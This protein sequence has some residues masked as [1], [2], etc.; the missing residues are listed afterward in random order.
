MI[1]PRKKAVIIGGSLGGLFAGTLL[2]SIGWD[3]DIYERSKGDLDSRGGGI[4][5][6]PE[7][8][9]VMR[10][11]GALEGLAA[12]GV[13]SRNRVVF[14]PDGSLLH[15]DPAPQTQTSWSL[16]YSNLKKL[17]PDD[18]YHR[19]MTLEDIKQVE[20]GSFATAIFA[21]GTH[22]SGDIVIGA[23]GNGSSVRGLLWLEAEPS[24]AGYTAWRGL[25]PESEMPPAAIRDLHGDFAFASNTG[26]H[27]LG[28]LVPGDHSDV[29]KGHRLYNWVW[30]RVMDDAMR[31]D[32][33]TDRDGR[34]RH[35]SIPEGKLSD[36]WRD[37]VYSEA[38]AL[39][40]EGFRDVVL[41]TKQP[42][43]QAIRDLTVERMVNQRV[44]L[45]GDSAFI[46]RPHTAASTSKAAS[47]ALDL[48]DALN[49]IPDVDEALGRWEPRQLILGQQLYRSGKGMGDHLM[50]ERIGEAA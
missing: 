49:A 42:F 15:H 25:V 13:R 50:F 35:F 21:D 37:D 3:V 29:R 47:N 8:T 10:R 24:Y 31:E 6:Q 22:A 5:L 28:Y 20:D 33:M 27:I 30:Y 16:I 26:S 40:P 32:V 4:V 1:G 44:I 18:H 11:T 46:P 9:E 2:R 39:L 36:A 41:A 12:S 38:Q 43:A 48:V 19:S 7:V 45:L 34:A 14:R 17:F 23:D